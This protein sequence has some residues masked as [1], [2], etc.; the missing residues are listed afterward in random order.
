MTRVMRGDHT[1]QL[2]RKAKRGQISISA[3]LVPLADRIESRFGVRPLWIS[4]DAIPRAGTT[5]AV[6]PRLNVVFER[7]RD[8]REF[9]SSPYSFD[10]VKQAAIAADFFAL[11]SEKARSRMLRSITGARDGDD[12]FVCFSAFEPAAIEDAHLSVPTADISE[13]ARRAFGDQFWEVSRAFGAPVVFLHTE[14]Q[15]ASHQA[16]PVLAR[17]D[18]EYRDLVAPR[19]E[20][21]YL[22]RRTTFV[23]LDSK[24]NFDENYAGNWYYYW[25]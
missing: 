23:P 17:L 9:E 4:V 20:F 5:G 19:D 22:E 21:G 24:E 12:L 2:A 13:I 7:T 6:R 16:Q 8:F 18:D 1:Y 3:P 10:P 14:A 15:V 11:V 25:K